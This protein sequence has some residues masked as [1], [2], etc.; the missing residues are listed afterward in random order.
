MAPYG[1]RLDTDREMA[2]LCEYSGKKLLVQAGIKVPRG[3]LATSLDEVAIACK[4]IGPCVLKAQ[5]PI[6]KRGKSGGIQK[7]NNREEAINIAKDMFGMK[8]GGHE[9][10]KILLEE[11]AIINTECYVAITNDTRTKG[12]MLV[13]SAMGGMDVEEISQK[14]PTQMVFKPIPFGNTLSREFIL[15]AIGHLPLVSDQIVETIEQLFQVYRLHD[16]EL[17]EINPLVISSDADIIA[18]D[19]KFI[20][21]DSSIY[22]QEQLRNEIAPEKQTSLEKRAAQSGLK[23]IE[24]GGNV[25]VIAN[26]AGLTMTTMDAI[27]FFGG[28]PAN[29][30]EIGGEAYTKSKE[31]LEILLQNPRI[32]S[33][34]VNFCGAFA[35]TDVMTEGIVKAWQDLEPDIPVFFSINGTGYLEAIA[36]VREELNLEPFD[37]MD[38]AVIKAVEAAG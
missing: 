16:A 33:I 11:I 30:L 14:D 32:K 38:E 27:T 13:F 12:P 5:V 36:M 24:L 3:Q 22:R 28:K 2:N 9:V 4:E 21:D 31:A 34:L 1:T 25:G 8:I 15:A 6:G 17:V 19:C 35:R 37:L 20:L 18:L 7:A 29:F 23:Y 26:G 10:K